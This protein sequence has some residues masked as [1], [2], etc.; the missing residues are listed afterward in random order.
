MHR[1]QR[2]RRGQRMADM[3]AAEDVDMRPPAHPRLRP[4]AAS[5][6]RLHRVDQRRS[7]TS[8]R[9]PQHWPISGP[10]GISRV[11]QFVPRA[12]CS[13]VPWSVRAASPSGIP[14]RLCRPTLPTRGR[15]TER[16][17]FPR[18]VDRHE[19]ELAAADRAEDRAGRD[20]HAGALLARRRAFASGHFDQGD[21]GLAAS[22]KSARLCTWRS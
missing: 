3:A 15:V 5:S 9:P 7:A 10:S 18:L 12:G 16:Q 11:A 22:R 19:F 2:K 20:E 6:S 17:H 8:T 13:P 21:G 14:N 1:Q 4:P